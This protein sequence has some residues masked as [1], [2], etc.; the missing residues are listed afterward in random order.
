M[1]HTLGIMAHR[2]AS[3]L[4]P[5]N[6][7]ARA[8]ARGKPAWVMCVGATPETVGETTT[9]ELLAQRRAGVAAT[10]L[11]DPRLVLAANATAP[12]GAAGQASAGGI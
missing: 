12:D 3:A 6:T 8:A 2:G 1:S 9:P 11:N 10:I 5:E 4:A 7:L